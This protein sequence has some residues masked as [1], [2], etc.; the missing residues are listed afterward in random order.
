M[1]RAILFLLCATLA[2][3]A[4]ERAIEIR[5]AALYMSPDATSQRLGTVQR[6]RE[7]AVIE[8]SGN[9]LKVLA[10]T[11]QDREVTGW[12][13]TKGVVR[14]STPNGD[15]I[16]YGEAVDSEAQAQRRGG[17]KGAAQDA[18]RLYARMAEYF[19]KSPL[20][21]EALFR[22]ADI[23]WQLEKADVF[24]R[25]SAK[26]ADP[27]LRGQMS[28]DMLHEVRKKFPGTKWADLASY[29]LM[30]NKVCG[31]W[32]G[33]SKCPEK[34][35]GMYEDYVKDHPSSPKAA[36]ALYEAAWRRAALIEIYKTEAKN[37][38]VAEA[39]S[40]ALQLSQQIVSQFPQSDWAPR[41]QSLAYKVEQGIPT[42][43]NASE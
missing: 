16:I 33:A 30:E 39:R 10:N 37:D 11:Q 14:T 35:A 13:L 24:S 20:A 17:R 34:E 26:E 29:E 4:A 12:V 2:H 27:L 5:E 28:E 9:F 18:M 42:W 3:A 7:V 21:G 36:E 22:A 38:K 15:A 31:E 19:P 41:A 1:K 43:G 23:R 32:Q 6:G 40:R 25:P 8:T